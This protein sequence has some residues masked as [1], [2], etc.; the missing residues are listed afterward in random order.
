MP[1][2]ASSV[3][4]PGGLPRG[5]GVGH[6]RRGARRTVAAMLSR[7]DR[8]L[9]CTFLYRPVPSCAVLCLPLGRGRWTA[10]RTWRGTSTAVWAYQARYTAAG[11]SLLLLTPSEKAMLPLLEAAPRSPSTSPRSATGARG[12]PG[13]HRAPTVGMGG[14]GLP[15]SG[16]LEAAKIP[17]H[18]TKVSHWR[19]GCTRQA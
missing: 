18:L 19:Q 12:I 15:I 2:C 1:S 7:A 10:P 14:T 6:S 3:S 11:R 16:V 4:L 13:K 17:F 8:A 5:R 9:S